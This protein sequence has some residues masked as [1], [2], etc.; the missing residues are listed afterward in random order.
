MTLLAAFFALLN[1]Y[2]AQTDIAV[3]CPIAN[4][5]R[6]E[7]EPLIGMLVNTLVIRLDLTGEPTF[8]ELLQRLR[9]VVLEA[10]DHQDLPY[11]VMASKLHPER[12]T[13]F[14]PFTQVMF[15]LIDVPI[16]ALR[17]RWNHD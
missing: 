10:Y 2:T 5:N 16:P 8:R 3:G 12:D 4:R 1:R 7:T 6:V 14:T 13:R 11:S 17:S 15:S 9:R